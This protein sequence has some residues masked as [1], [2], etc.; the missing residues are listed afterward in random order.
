ML[1]W[2]EA[3]Q[4]KISSLTNQNILLN[5]TERADMYDFDEDLEQ[6]TNNFDTLHSMI[7]ELNIANRPIIADEIIINN[8]AFIANLET[9]RIN[10]IIANDLLNNVL[11][12][13]RDIE[14]DQINFHFL[15]SKSSIKTNQI[16]QKDISSLLHRSDNLS[17]NFL[18]INGNVRAKDGLQIHG[19]LNNILVDEKNILLTVTNQTFIRPL[20]VNIAQIGRM[21]VKSING[22]NISTSKYWQNP[23]QFIDQITNLTV[24]DLTISGYLNDV[25]MP[26]LDDIILKLNENQEITAEYSFDELIIEN[27]EIPGAFNGRDISDLVPIDK[28]VYEINQDI[29]FNNISV[30]N[31]KISFQLNDITVHDGKLDILLSDSNEEQQVTGE[32]VFENVILDGSISL[33]GHIDS[34]ILQKMNPV[35]TINDNLHLRGDKSFLGPIEIENLLNVGDIITP[36]NSYS[37]MRLKKEGV[38]LIDRVIKPTLHLTQQMNVGEIFVD[39]I[40][41]HNPS[42]FVTLGTDEPQ[43]IEGLKIIEGDLTLDGNS[44]VRSINNINVE[45][46]DNNVIKLTEDQ[47]I[48]GEY[49]IRDVTVNRIFSDKIMIGDVAVSEKSIQKENLTLILENDLII[50]EFEAKSIFVKGLVNGLAFDEIINDVVFKN[51]KELIRGKKTFQNLAIDNL[52]VQNRL[53]INLNPINNI[54]FDD[55]L[56]LNNSEIENIYFIGEFNGIKP[57]NFGKIDDVQARIVTDEHT[58]DTLVI[59]GKVF[60]D[61]N[62][63]NDIIIDDIVE[64]TL[65]IN[66]E[67]TIESATFK[68]FFVN[69]S[70]NLNGHIENFDLDN[71][72]WSND[73]ADQI[74]WDEKSFENGLSID[75]STQFGGFINNFNITRFCDFAMNRIEVKDLIIRGNAFFVHGPKIANINNI[76]VTNIFENAWFKDQDAVLSGNIEFD[77]MIFEKDLFINVSCNSENI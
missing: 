39:T 68:S 8:T 31:M 7:D 18:T 12:I 41:D 76:N 3:S 26:V 2:C 61:S 24:K 35:I 20:S 30:D 72:V 42:N 6:I 14:I 48:T 45:D 43:I 70:L 5:R 46:L 50:D 28:G 59:Y 62:K 17:I 77:E 58:F 67:F 11:N 19:K 13:D 37:L 64:N 15:E 4:S 36:D 65:K 1:N 74:I 10:N 38:T 40:N 29:I 54:I 34:E 66:E 21:R 69:N 63:I 75:G 57:E 51:S 22:A 52:T 44:S 32:K 49:Y 47:I 33:Q 55:F 73:D 23:P 16:N 60:I 9:N 25:D 53:D 71:V 56:K 27:L